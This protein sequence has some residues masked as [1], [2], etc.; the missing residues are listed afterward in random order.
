MNKKI[1]LITGI[2][3]QDGIYLCEFLLKKN[4]K[5]YGIDRKKTVSNSKRLFD[6]IASNKNVKILNGDLCDQASI[7]EIISKTKP[8]EIYN[9]AAQSDVAFSFK[10]PVYTGD[11]NALG[12]LR[13]LESIR[14]LNLEKKIKFY[15]ANTS[16][17][18]G[19][20]LETPQ[21]EKTIFNP[22]SPYAISKLFSYWT[23]KNYRE[24]FKIF[25]VNGILFNHESPLRGNQF[26]TKKIIKSLVKIKNNSNEIL[27][28][29]NIYS[30]RDWG[31]AEDYVEMMWKM[32][33]LKKPD[34]FVISTGKQYSVKEFV[35][36]V[37]KILNI[38]IV[39]KFKGLKEHAVWKKGNKNKII[40][41]ISKEYFRPSD[42]DNLLG[43]STKARKKLKWSP[44]RNIDYLIKD[45]ITSEINAN[46]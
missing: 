31:H 1:A 17:L 11:V 15:Q 10:Q 5:V 2:T 34:D 21:N 20:V 13:L 23:V 33:Q 8:S 4:Y 7:I 38:N 41:K 30:K 6:K 28:L 39:W 12:T 14:I 25:A 42:V 19:K 3:G 35:N 27:Y 16:E 29:G 32:L 45:M 18:Y 36:K 22:A 46:K 9:L 43:D 44:K 26:V 40:I 37:C 24:S